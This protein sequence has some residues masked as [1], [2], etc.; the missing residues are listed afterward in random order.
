MK[1]FARHT[2]PAG[3][4]SR[5]AISVR[6]TDAGYEPDTITVAAGHPARIAFTRETESTCA[7]E[8]TFP[9]L[10][11][12]NALPVGKPV[13]VELPTAAAGEHEFTCAMGMYRGRLVVTEDHRGHSAAEHAIHKTQGGPR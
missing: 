3:E 9:D 2:D 13:V 1:L 8:V 4:D 5:D 7:A 12:S 6:V 11:V 10:G